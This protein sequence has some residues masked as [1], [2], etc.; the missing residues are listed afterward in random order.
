MAQMEN[1]QTAA[2]TEK[3][4][5]KERTKDWIKPPKAIMK[6]VGR[7]MAQFKMLRDGDRVLL[8][9]SGGKDSMA[10]LV[11][12]KHIQRHAP[13]KFELAACTIDPEIPGFDPSPLKAWCAKMDVPYFYE[14]EDMVGMADQYMKG[15]SFCSFCARQKRGILYSTCRREGYNVLALAQHLD[16]LA[17]S[18]IMSAFNA[19]QLR[20]MKAH[21]VN[22]DGDIRIIR[23]LVRV[24]ENQTRDFAT[25]AGLP[26]IE[27]NCPACYAKPQAR[28]ETKQ[29][30]LEQERK[31]KHLYANLWTAMQPL[32]A[33]DNHEG[34][35]ELS[36]LSDNQTKGEA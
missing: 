5:K 23:P 31:N 19:G 29:L 27:D 1:T 12:L 18:F 28:A 2:N 26:V 32:I 7:A 8:G 25:S 15:D 3:L 17:E 35:S 14:T 36:Q 20:T 21:Y 33:D 4:T 34:Q 24:R 13:V 11:I 9:L 16:D 10:L 6:P 30:L 22:D